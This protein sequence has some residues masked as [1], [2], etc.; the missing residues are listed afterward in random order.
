MGTFHGIYRAVVV[1]AAI[2]SAEVACKFEVPDVLGTGAAWALPCVPVGSRAV[3]KVGAGIWVMFEGGDTQD[4][5]IQSGWASFA[6]LG[7]RKDFQ[8]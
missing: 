2:R 8:P 7:G 1:N 3:P 5:I 6:P 4:P